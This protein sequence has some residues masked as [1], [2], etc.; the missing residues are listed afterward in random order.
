MGQVQDVLVEEEVLLSQLLCLSVDS[1]DLVEDGSET[2]L[3]SGDLAEQGR[4]RAGNI[5]QRRRSAL[6]VKGRYESAGAVLDD[7][8][9]LDG[10]RNEVSIAR[11]G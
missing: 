10:L 1:H 7:L 5:N 4:A 3:L 9:L 6:D 2:F 11:R 8:L